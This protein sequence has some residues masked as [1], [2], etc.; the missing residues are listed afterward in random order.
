M[1]AKS[2]KPADNTN[3]LLPTRNGTDTASP[4]QDIIFQTDHKRQR[5]VV[6]GLG[7]VAIAFMYAHTTLLS[8]PL[9][10]ENG[11]LPNT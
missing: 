11:T 9:Y 5:I 1:E 2:S 3:T 6:V 10:R 7:M 8:H 4:K